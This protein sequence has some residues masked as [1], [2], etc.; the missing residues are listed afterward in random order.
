LIILDEP[1]HGADVDAT[2]EI[3]ELINKLVDDGWHFRIES[4]SA[5]KAT[6]W[7]GSPPSTRPK[8]IM[9]AAIH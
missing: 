3:Q 5:V 2:V 6:W 1:T 9:Y 7:R 4:W 8:K